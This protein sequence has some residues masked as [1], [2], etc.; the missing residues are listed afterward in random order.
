MAISVGRRAI[1]Q[2]N[3][4]NSAAVRERAITAGAQGSPCRALARDVVTTLAKV[5][6]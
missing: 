6:C 4:D 1:P 3:I 5:G 2:A